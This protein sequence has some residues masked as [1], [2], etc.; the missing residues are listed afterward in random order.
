[1]VSKAAGVLWGLCWLLRGVTTG[2]DS[3]DGPVGAGLPAPT[4]RSRRLLDIEQDSGSHRLK[5][6]TPAADSDVSYKIRV[7]VLGLGKYPTLSVDGRL[8]AAGK[9]AL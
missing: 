6:R 1:M 5:G 4:G 2:F 8:I 3:C 9:L 7:E